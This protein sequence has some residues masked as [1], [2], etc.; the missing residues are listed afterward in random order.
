MLQLS[1]TQKDTVGRRRKEIKY[2]G[3]VLTEDT[4]RYMKLKCNWEIS[5]GT[6]KHSC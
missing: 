3:L 4:M 6:W 1:K 2:R 5:I